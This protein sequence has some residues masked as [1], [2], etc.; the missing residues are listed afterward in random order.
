MSDKS[1]AY[2]DHIKCRVPDLEGWRLRARRRENPQDGSELHKDDTVFEA[3]PI[4]EAARICLIS[5]GEHLRLAWT[6]VKAEEVY[7]IAHYTTLRGALLAASQAV[8]ILGPDEAEIRRGRGLAAIAESYKRSRQFHKETLKSP[9]LTEVEKQQTRAQMEWLTSRMN[10]ARKAGGDV[11]LNISDVVI[12]YAAEVTYRT[13][14]NLQNE[15]NL[16]WRQMSGDAHALTWALAQRVVFQPAVKGQPLS[17]GIA[18]GSL[19]EI[20]QPFEASFQILKRGWA[21]YDRRCEM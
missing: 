7:P 16:L 11:L 14:A 20:A 3:H 6:A 15:V 8:Y 21:L 19:E 18:G 13:N 4:S 17:T 5:A 9:G 1:E 2:Y 10:E 12:P